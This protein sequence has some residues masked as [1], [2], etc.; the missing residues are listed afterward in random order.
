M[1][2]ARPDAY[3]VLLIRRSVVIFTYAMIM[4]SF[5]LGTFAEQGMLWYAQWPYR[6]I[7]ELQGSA[8]TLLKFNPPSHTLPDLQGYNCSIGKRRHVNRNHNALIQL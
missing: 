6:S 2:I 4:I 3:I 7:P 8:I 1:P 5:L